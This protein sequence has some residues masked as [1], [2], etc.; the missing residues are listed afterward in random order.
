MTTDIEH[1]ESQAGNWIEWARRP[2]F[3]A[4][5]YYRA[6]FFEILP[7]PDGLTVEVGCGEGRLTRDLA[8][9]GYEITGVE[10]VSAL[11]RAAREAHPDGTYVQATA[12]DLPFED[13]SVRLL[14]AYNSLM[15]I[16]DVDG[17]LQ[18]F[19][20]VLG[21]GGRLCVTITHPMADGVRYDREDV[22]APFH[23]AGSYLAVAPFDDVAERGGL[24]MHFAGWHRPLALYSKAI[25]GA[26]LLIEA[27][28]EPEPVDD[29]GPKWDRWRRLPMFM[30]LRCLKI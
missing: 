3:D 12:T 7:P 27:I 1:W 5:W 13:G 25:E 22:A 28:R 17:A 19:A 23:L 6:S 18:E 9:R 14:V 10:P 2:G 16:D 24:R 21:P 4:Y 8:E 30:G 20:R 26:G 15:D 11:L 29:A